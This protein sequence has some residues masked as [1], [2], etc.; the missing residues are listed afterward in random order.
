MSD[1]TCSLPDCARPHRARGFCVSHY[2]A[3]ILG[4]RRR[5]PRET[6]TCVI[7]STR[8]TRRRDNKA[9][10]TCS[11]RCRA[12]L[13]FGPG[14]APV[15]PYEW[16][17]DAVRRAAKAGAAIIE[18]FDREDIFERDRWTCQACQRACTLPDPFVLNAATIDHIVPLVAGGAHTR[19]NAQTLCLSCN[20]AKQA[21]I[22]PAA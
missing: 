3:L 11:T 14:L 17:T 8:V 2:N 7:C 18:T 16:R 12:V 6:R 19:W 21:A 4:E 20:S 5:H 22:S 1:R 9:R 13:Q 15:S 10:P